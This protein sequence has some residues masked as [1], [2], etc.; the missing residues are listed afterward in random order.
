M[1]EVKV[2]S[3]CNRCT[4]QDQD[5]CPYCGAAFA[6]SGPDPRA[7]AVRDNPG[8]PA[9]KP[10]NA[11]N[12]VILTTGPVRAGFFYKYLMALFP[13]VLVVICII[14]RT[15][16]ETMFQIGSSSFVSAVPLSTSGYT[17]G[18]LS[19]YAMPINYATNLTILMIAPV[20]IFIFFA[21]T[22]WTMRMTELWTST[23]LTLGLSALAGV[24]MTS[25]GGIS[26]S[27]STSY[28]L[29][30]LQW[31][32]FLVQPFCFVAAV[33]IIL[34][35]EKFRA[36]ILYTITREGLWIRGGFLNIQEHMIP[37]NQIGRI[38]LEQ[39][40]LGSIFNYG[41]L[42]PQSS[43]RW[44]QE[45]SFRG[46]GGASQKDNFG[47]GLGFGKGREEGSRYPLDCLYGIHDPKTAQ[48]IL[49]DLICR[50]DQREDEQVTYLKKI[51]EMNVAMTKAE[52]PGILPQEAPPAAE[53]TLPGDT[54][55]RPPEECAMDQKMP[56][57]MES[58]ITRIQ[59]TGIPEAPVTPVT[60]TIR[61]I[62]PL[63]KN[64]NSTPPEI[65]PPD[66]VLDT[67]RKLAELRDSG[68]ITEEEFTLKKTEL[69][70]R[71]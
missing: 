5:T 45:M 19:Q 70:K 65:H 71:L 68:V 21:A 59:N 53:C 40:F 61:E 17:T 7:G 6:K 34:S 52:R 9:G 3:L 49:T 33:V 12:P 24:L 69:L 42:I 41:T 20:G 8:E 43:T 64:G 48:K 23:S 1:D 39:D 28:L 31:I 4:D 37:H 18:T 36:S 27:F 46:I 13:I 30:Y 10:E 44:G 55:N 14:T 63:V 26:P 29:L 32:E 16:L 66:S 2:C 35:T 22:G 54:G 56:E 57:P 67:L 62:P 15:V 51:Y 58:I 47:M 50:H 11:G 25:L 60:G 38:V